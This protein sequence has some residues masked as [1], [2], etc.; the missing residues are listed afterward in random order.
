MPD[1]KRPNYFTLQF[2]EE[3]DFNAE[4]SYHRDVRHRHN[5]ALHG[6][7]V[8][9]NGLRVTLTSETTGVVTVTPGVAID[10]EGR[11][12]IL[13]DQRTD[14]T[15]RFGSQRTLYLVIRY[16]AVTLEPD[17]Y[18][19]TG[20]SDQY[21]RFTERPEFVLRLINQKMDQASC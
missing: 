6:W 3:A 20:V 13:V 1:I 12:I 4:Q 10:R 17:R 18:R 21:T 2:L 5:L 15:D 14:I 9:G 8:V 19:G 16:N 11:E 7:G